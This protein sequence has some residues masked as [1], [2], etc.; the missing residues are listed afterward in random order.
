[1]T[2]VDRLQQILSQIRSTLAAKSGQAQR[3]QGAGTSGR[4]SATRAVR[5]TVE[6]LKTQI[7]SGLAAA[8][9]QYTQGRR[10]ARR[11]FLASV[12]LAEFG[13]GMANDRRF[14]EIVDG[15]LESFE[16]EPTLLT[17]IDSVLEELRGR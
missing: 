17:G 8:D 3:S 15:V 10:Q 13:V 5:P 16:Q 11:M 9:L 7:S 14:A 6:E 4:A 2:A 12:L 1:M